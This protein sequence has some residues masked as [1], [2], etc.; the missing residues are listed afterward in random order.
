MI[1]IENDAAMRGEAFAT[2][3][4]IHP[5]PTLFL[6]PG[7]ALLVLAWFSPGWSSLV[8][9]ALLYGAAWTGLVLS[10]TGWD[11]LM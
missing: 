3:V 8:W 2:H 9:F 7:L 1:G 11:A 5:S 6:G 10:S 4:R